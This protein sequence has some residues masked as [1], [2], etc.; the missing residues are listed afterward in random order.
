MPRSGGVIMINI[1]ANGKI[2]EPGN[3]STLPRP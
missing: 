1:C 2:S 3:A